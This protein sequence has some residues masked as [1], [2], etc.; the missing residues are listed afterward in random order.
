LRSQIATTHV[1]SAVGAA[2]VMGEHTHLRYTLALRGLAPRQWVWVFQAGTAV[3]SR[4]RVVEPNSVSLV[5]W[6]Q[7]FGGSEGRVQPHRF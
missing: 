3:S 1:W 5:R 6:G 7:T 2:L 4:T